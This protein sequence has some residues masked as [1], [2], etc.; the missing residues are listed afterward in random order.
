MEGLFSEIGPFVFL[1]GNS[2]I[3]KF[4][5]YSWNKAAHIMFLESPAGVGMNFKYIL[6][7]STNEE[8]L[9]TY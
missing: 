8:S 7:F 9:N 6:G 5:K 4:N 3:P 2:T 1:H